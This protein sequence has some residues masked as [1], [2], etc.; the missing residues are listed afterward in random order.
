[1]LFEAEYSAFNWG[2]YIACKYTFNVPFNEN[3]LLI[4]MQE[5]VGEEKAKNEC[6]VRL[7]G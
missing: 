2:C 6:A 4:E 3:K 5:L 1:V 7:S